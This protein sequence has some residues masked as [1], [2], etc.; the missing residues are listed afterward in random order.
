LESIRG[1]A[2]RLDGAVEAALVGDSVDVVGYFGD[3]DPIIAVGQKQVA[4]KKG[5]RSVR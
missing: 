3:A 5:Q 2:F 4:A 1:R